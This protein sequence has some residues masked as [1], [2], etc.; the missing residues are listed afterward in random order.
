M[1]TKF[2]DGSGLKEDNSRDVIQE[3]PRWQGADVIGR[4]DA[5]VATLAVPL[6]LPL[7]ASALRLALSAFIHD[8]D[9]LM[10]T[11]A[12]IR[13]VLRLP[14]ARTRLYASLSSSPLKPGAIGPYQVFDRNAKSLQK[15]RS[16]ARDGGT[17]SRTVDYVREEVADRMIERLLDIKRKFNTILDV[18]SGSGHFSKLLE[19][20]TTKKAVMLDSSSTYYS[21]PK[22][23][24]G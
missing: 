8:F 9:S 17:R 13:P 2:K 19:E 3:T 22:L 4:L 6:W 5:S 1:Y 12:P 23:A 18:G 24:A 7:A 21:G 16:V 10:A 20:E 15:D 11:F 14:A